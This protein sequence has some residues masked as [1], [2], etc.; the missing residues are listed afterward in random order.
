[1]FYYIKQPKVKDDTPADQ[2]TEIKN[3]FSKK[4]SHMEI[5]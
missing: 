3:D 2:A 4:M 1:M 5:F